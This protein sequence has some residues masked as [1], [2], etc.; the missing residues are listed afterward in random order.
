MTMQTPALVH[1]AL[2][3]QP[4]ATNQYPADVANFNLLI[5]KNRN[6]ERSPHYFGSMKIDG[7]WYIVSTWIRFQT[8]NGEQMLSN[9]VRPA[10]PEEAKRNEDRELQYASRAAANPVTAQNNPLAATAPIANPLENGGVENP[11]APF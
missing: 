4:A 9:S 6:N 2:Q 11:P 10:T 1:P 5:S 8:G 3:A 7:R